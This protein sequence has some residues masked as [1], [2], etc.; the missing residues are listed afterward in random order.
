M[1][2]ARA[3]VFDLGNV[4]L[5]WQPE[6]YYT[7]KYGSEHAAKFFEAGQKLGV[8]IGTLSYRLSLEAE[9][10]RVKRKL[11]VIKDEIRNNTH[12]ALSI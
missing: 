11:E 1:P 6:L 3:A 8:N 9:K 10:E 7:E 12:F 5:R 2:Q 4:L